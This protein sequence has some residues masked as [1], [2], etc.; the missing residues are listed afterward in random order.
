M[1]G[2]TSV[3]KLLLEHGANPNVEDSSTGTSPLHDAAWTGFL[4]TVQLLV[5]HHADPQARDKRNRLPVDLAREQD[6]V[7]VVDFLESLQNP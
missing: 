4:E 2:S 1:M 6:H 3:A 7:D 5:K